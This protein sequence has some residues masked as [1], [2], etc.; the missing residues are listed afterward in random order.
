MLP[1]LALLSLAT[2]PAARS[3]D[4][5]FENGHFRRGDGSL[6]VPLG[7]FY[8]NLMPRLASG[9]LEELVPFQKLDED[10]WREWFAL[11]EAN[12]CNALR[13]FCRQHDEHNEYPVEWTLDAGG[14]VNPEIMATFERYFDI[15]QEYGISFLMTVLSEPRGSVYR[16]WAPILRSH[17]HYAPNGWEWN[18]FVPEGLHG[19]RLL[20]TRNEYFTD[21]EAVALQKQYLAELIPRLRENPAVFAVELYNEMAWYGEFGWEGQEL[22]F[23]WSREMIDTIREHAPEL[24]ICFSLAGHGVTGID[25]LTWCE[26]LPTDFFSSHYYPGLSGETAELDYGAMSALIHDYCAARSANWPGESGVIDANVPDEL[27]RLALRDSIWLTVAS[28]GAGYMQWPIPRQPIEHLAEY[29]MAAELLAGEDWLAGDL[30]PPQITIDIRELA[31]LFGSLEDRQAKLASPLFDALRRYE[32]L[33][34]DR[35]IAVALRLGPGDVD[36]ARFDEHALDSLEP[37]LSVPAGYQ[38]RCLATPGLERGIAYFRNHERASYG[39]YEL[40]RGVS[41]RF[42]IRANLPAGEYRFTVLDLGRGETEVIDA[43]SPGTVFPARETT[44][45]FAVKFE[46]TT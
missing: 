3:A 16:H 44:S 18:S 7:G 9:V 46:R 26:E 12:G 38:M 40:R 11:L 25:P 6:F 27:R 15:G 21:P 10:G 19:R 17:P 14:H 37:R 29:R 28:G 2:L 22:E 43:E 8:G 24:P 30:A 1:P 45:D 23:A 42:D 13:V 35:G 36:G 39:R 31:T 20:Q 4:M 5:V 32:R 41:R 34:L 33:A